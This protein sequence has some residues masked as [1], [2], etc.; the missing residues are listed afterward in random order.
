MYQSQYELRDWNINT[1]E[2]RQNDGE[3]E[4][5]RERNR[6]KQHRKRGSELAF[7]TAEVMYKYCGWIFLRRNHAE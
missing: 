3:T 5:R 7:I 4:R 1:D 2:M 6:K